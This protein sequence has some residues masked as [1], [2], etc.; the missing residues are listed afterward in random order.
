MV[1]PLN[2]TTLLSTFSLVKACPEPTDVAKALKQQECQ[3]G[4]FH[5]FC[6]Y[7]VKGEGQTIGKGSGERLFDFATRL[8]EKRLD[9]YPAGFGDYGSANTAV[10]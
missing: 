5:K 6:G 8:A 1:S 3:D 2:K 10:S 4:V 9:Y 7:L